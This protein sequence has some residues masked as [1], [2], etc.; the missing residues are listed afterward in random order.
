VLAGNGACSTGIGTDEELLLSNVDLL[1]GFYCVYVSLYAPCIVFI[2]LKFVYRFS[3]I[4]G[5]F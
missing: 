5:L 4:T 3:D 2:F 1:C